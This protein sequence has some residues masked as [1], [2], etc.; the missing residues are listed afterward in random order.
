MSGSALRSEPGDR[1]DPDSISR[2]SI[3]RASWVHRDS[4]ELH[5]SF[6]LLDGSTAYR[7]V[8]RYEFDIPVSIE[9][10]P[11]QHELQRATALLHLAASMSYYKAALPPEITVST[12]LEP[13]SV[14]EVLGAL[15]NEGLAEMRHRAGVGSRGE[16]PSLIVTGTESHTTRLRRSLPTHRPVVV[17]IGGG[18]DSLVALDLVRRSGRTPVLLAVTT[19]GDPLATLSLDESLPI[20]RVRRTIDPELIALNRRGAL[21]GHVPVTAVISTIGL[22]A[23]VM[24]G[25]TEV[26]MAN[27]RDASIPTLVENG[28]GINHQ[29]SKSW[30]FERLLGGVVEREVGDTRVFSLLRPVSEATIFR[31]FAT[32]PEFHRQIASCNVVRTLGGGSA[33]GK[34]WCG[35]CPK[36]RYSFLGLAA[37]SDRRQVLDTFDGL[38]LFDDEAGLDDYLGLLELAGRVRP[39]E[40]VGVSSDAR[41]L[42]RRCIDNGQWLGSPLMRAVAPLLGDTS[43]P[44][45]GGPNLVAEPYWPALRMLAEE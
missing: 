26:V 16:S 45:I 23:A 27:E 7:F 17:P 15:N 29:Y 22:V 14:V 32:M 3:D 19:F 37:F 12:P 2:F 39:F 10:S 21:N 44:W 38:N 24:I 18:K 42:M 33:Q 31:H 20:V 25:A 1:F 28:R 41:Y 8:E 40:C 9:R 35:S 5:Y 4:L 43:A 36:C 30:E 11:S 6:A 34:R 13:G